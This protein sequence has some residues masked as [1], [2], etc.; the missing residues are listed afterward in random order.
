MTRDPK[1]A[2]GYRTQVMN[3]SVIPR[4]YHTSAVLLPD[5]R[6]FLAGGNAAPGD[7]RREGRVGRPLHQPPSDPPEPRIPSE[8]WEAEVFSPPYLFLPGPRPEITQAPK[9]LAYGDRASVT[10]TNATANGSL[11]LVRLPRR[12]TAWT[13]ASI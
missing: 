10:V 5:A 9:S 2:G 1:A 13:W 4:L 11:V 6:V 8:A 12:A 3:P 7:Q